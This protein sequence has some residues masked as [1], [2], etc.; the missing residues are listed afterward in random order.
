MKTFKQH[1]FVCLNKRPEDRDCCAKRGSQALYERLKQQCREAGLENIRINKSGCLGNCQDGP[2]AV[3]YPEG[4]WLTLDQEAVD[5][6]IEN[7][8]N[9]NA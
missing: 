1:V 3:I 9:V 6:L 5:Q 8:S 4:E 7:L 2:A